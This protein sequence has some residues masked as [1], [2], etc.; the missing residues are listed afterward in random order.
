MAVSGP[1][2]QCQGVTKRFGRTLA[3]D[4][5]SFSVEP[6]EILSVLGPSGC[7]KTSMLRLIAGFESPDLG[8]I[9]IQGKVVVGR[10]AH[11]PP[12]RRNVGMVF[13]EYALFPHLTVAQNVSF[14]L[15]RLTADERHRRLVEVLELVRLTGLEAR[16]PH[17]LSGGQQQRV[18]LARTL[19]PRPVTVLLDEPFSNLDAGMRWEM[20]HEIETILRENDISTVFVTHD[21]EQAFAM[22]DRIGVMVDGRLHQLD[23]PDVVYHSPA[24]PFVARLAGTSDL[25]KGEA[26]GGMAVT[27]IGTLPYASKNGALA[28]GMPMDLLVHPDDFQVVPD[29]EGRHMVRSREFRGDETILVVAMPSGATL[30]CRQLSYSTL[31]P[32][33]RATLTPE[34]AMPFVAFERSGDKV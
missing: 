9:S 34:K 14:G 23:T 32:G 26:R 30:S 27:E 8:Q 25:L 12:D 24:T 2:V 13:Q 5:L 6:G 28:D 18:A 3:V 29:A 7:G 19:A 10:S 1:V 31:A 15:Q 11:V 17:E 16:Y 33:D 4:D 20:R 22:A 21:R